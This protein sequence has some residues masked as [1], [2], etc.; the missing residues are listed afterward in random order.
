MRTEFNFYG[1][2]SPTNGK[3]YI[4]GNE[5]SMGEDFRNVKRY[6]E[7]KNV[8][9]TILLLQAENSYNG[10]DFET[11]ACNLCM[12]EAVKAGIDK[13][14]VSDQRL[15]DLCAEKELVGE[16]GRFKSQTELMEYLDFCTKPYR[17]KQGFYGVQ[18]LD[19]PSWEKLKAYGQVIKG[20]K[21]LLPNIYL[22]SNLLNM[23]EPKRLA[24]NETNTFVAYDKYLNLFL[25]ESGSNSLMYDDYPF[26][27]DYIICGYSI[28]NYQQCAEICKNRGVE[29]YTV[30]QSFSWVSNGRLVMRRITEPD[31]RWQSNMAMGFGVRDFAFFTYFTKPRV[32]LK[33]AFN[34]DGIDGTAFINR[35]GS[36]TKLYYYAKKI[37]A[38][39]KAFAPVMLKYDYQN[40]YIL[41]EK[42]KSPEDF[43][44]T[45]YAILNEDCPISVQPNEGV[46]LVTEHRG[47]DGKS[48]LYMVE[49]I[50]NIK[51]ELY[52][53]KPQ[54]VRISLGEGA[55]VKIYHRGKQIDKKINNGSFTQVLRVGDAIFI[56]MEN[57]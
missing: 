16:S 46:T 23:V 50:G 20:L 22:Q 38:E 39:M 21:K 52:G 47:K 25:D 29:F 57:K 51:H 5:Y 1:Y 34:T 30:L 3:Y 31:M 6:K 14:I 7:Y 54:R 9:F 49:N 13:I 32:R 53:G 41:C 33:D 55:V 26:R 11:S 10:E 4:D 35:D 15:K 27:R 45:K 12:T 56:E 8:G 18:L 28:R 40:S 2:C 42:G 24:E 37:I 44:Q 36:R 19:E 43:E 17:D 48:V